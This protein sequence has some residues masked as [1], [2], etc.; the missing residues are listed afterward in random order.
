MCLLVLQMTGLNV[1]EDRI[2]EVAS[3]ITDDNLNIISDEF[4]MVINQP[5]SIFETMIPW[6]QEQ[7]NKVFK[8]S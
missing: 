1:L 6:C 2:L 8:Y 7:H 3:I 5:E 4:E